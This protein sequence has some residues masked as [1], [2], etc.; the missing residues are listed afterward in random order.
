MSLIVILTDPRYT[1]PSP[2]DWYSAQIYLEER[3][4]QEGLQT[5]GY[6]VQRVAW[7]DPDF[8][9][10]SA[11]AAVFRSTWDYFHRFAEF[12]AWLDRVEGQ[13]RLINSAQ[14]VRWTADTN[15]LADLQRS[16]IE[17]P[18]TIFLAAHAIVSLA[19]LFASLGWERGVLKPAVSGAAR[20]TYLLDQAN[21]SQHES[22][23]QE[24]NAAES[25]LLQAFEEQIL[26]AGEIS[27]IVVGDRV[28]HAVRKI[29]KAGDFRV[30]DDHGGTAHAYEPRSDEIDFALRAV[31]ACPERPAY[32]RVD[33]IRDHRGRLAL[34]ELELIEPELFFRF[35]PPAAS[36]LA[37]E[38][39]RRV[40]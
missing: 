8:A 38:I 24:L 15:Y 16:D 37:A 23:F 5:L 21:V 7:S 6:E 12:G 29:A 11:R 27:L 10:G 17:I 22:I 33:L 28:T 26:T 18:E 40:K 4:L 32:A 20:H 1:S 2:D 14:T 31:A 25:M 30:Q 3:L 13:T 39:A 34:M 19:N 35:A 9:W 36:A